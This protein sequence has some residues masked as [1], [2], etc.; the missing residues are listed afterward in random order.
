MNGHLN[1]HANG[2]TTHQ[3]GEEISVSSDWEEQQL[4]GDSKEE[5]GQEVMRQQGEFGGDAAV[6]VE[7]AGAGL[8]RVGTD[9]HAEEESGDEEESDEVEG[10]SESEEEDGDML[11]AF[12]QQL[13]RKQQQGDQGASQQHGDQQEEEEQEEMEKDT[14]EGLA[15]AFPA[16]GEN[17]E[18]L[19]LER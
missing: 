12:E 19:E 3:P 9:E 6:E 13:R 11:D 7:E 17:P 16:A 8:Q 15:T 10:M 4:D 2:V 14:G 5:S 18:L 1:G